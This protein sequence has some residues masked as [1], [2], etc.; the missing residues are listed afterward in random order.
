[1]VTGDHL[2]TARK[3]AIDCGIVNNKEAYDNG[4]AMTGE[5]FRQ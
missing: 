3:I 2:D 1:M 5:E 4:V